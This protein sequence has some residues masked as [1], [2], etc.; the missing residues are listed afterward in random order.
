MQP[1]SLPHV[2]ITIRA[3]ADIV[4][5]ILQRILFVHKKF[6]RHNSWSEINYKSLNK[7]QNEQKAL[8]LNLA[9]EVQNAEEN[10]LYI[11][12][13]TAY[14]STYTSICQSTGKHTHTHTHHSIITNLHIH[15][16][17]YY[18]IQIYLARNYVH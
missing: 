7:I 15:K 1:N 13:C 8:H 3:F 10:T 2:Y 9:K 12:S 5:Q 18:Y 14:T 4:M 17:S 6:S 16:L 11:L